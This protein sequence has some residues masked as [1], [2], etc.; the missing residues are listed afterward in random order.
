MTTVELT[1]EEIQIIAVGL[2]SVVKSAGLEQQ[3][4]TEAAIAVSN[5]LAA[6]RLPKPNADDQL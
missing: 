4:L 3:N 2:N 6:A 1:D 5:K